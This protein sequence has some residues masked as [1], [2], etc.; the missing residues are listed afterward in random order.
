LTNTLRTQGKLR[1]ELF[2]V[3]KT[4]NIKLFN[5]CANTKTNEMY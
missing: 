3:A 2:D 1:S 4:V 5:A